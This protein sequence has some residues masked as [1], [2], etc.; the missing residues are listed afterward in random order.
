MRSIV[1]GTF[2]CLAL[3]SG[4]VLHQHGGWSAIWWACAGMITLQ[5]MEA[6]RMR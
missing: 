3:Q 2:A 5:A 4:A 6:W 1:Y